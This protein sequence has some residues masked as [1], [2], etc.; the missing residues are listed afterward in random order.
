MWESSEEGN[1]ADSAEVG[2]VTWTWA[3][4]SPSADHLQL[5]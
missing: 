4:K 2:Q 3:L 1:G 5:L